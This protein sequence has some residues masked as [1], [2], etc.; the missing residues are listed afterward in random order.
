MKILKLFLSSL[1][2]VM[3]ATTV[4]AGGVA[5]AGRTVT[6]PAEAYRAILDRLDQLQHRVDEL[7]STKGSVEKLATDV[8]DIYD[9]LDRVETKTLQDRVNFGVELRTRLD[10]FKTEDYLYNYVTGETKNNSKDNMW[11]NRFRLNMSA[12]IMDGLTFHGRLTVFKNWS[13]NDQPM[14]FADANAAHTPADTSVKLDRAYIDWVVPGMPIP[15]AIT[16]GRQ[17][18]S[19]GPPFELRENR[20]RQS[21]YP[22]LLFDGESDGIVATFGLSKYT[23]IHNNGF[24]LA[25]F[26]GFQNNDDMVSYKRPRNFLDDLNVFA[27]FFEGE[28]PAVPNSLFVL[29]YVRSN[30]HVDNPLHPTAS[31]GD[32]DNYVIHTQADNIMETGLD[33]FISWG[34]NKSH[35]NGDFGTSDFMDP[36][37]NLFTFRMPPNPQQGIY[38]GI[39]MGLLDDDGDHGHT[40]W[41][42]YTGLRYT[43]PVSMLNLPK[44]GFEYNHGS[45]YWFSYTMGTDDIYN[46][47]ATRGDAYDIYYIQPFNRYL[48]LRTGYTYVDYDYTG[49]GWHIGKPMDTEESL[50]NFYVLLDCR[51]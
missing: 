49:S 3:A 18:S 16:F 27:T 9:T 2:I 23:H 32:M 13:D 5:P 46:K 45:K 43:I 35:P 37:G 24:R 38:P 7:E 39:G 20:L 34:L 33:F 1:C 11:T 10:N 12:D 14:M 22:S 15:L 4:Y 48:F 17:P 50:Q 19:E 6:L 47:L 44:I 29:G 28:I 36:A 51:F 8:D 40:G 31:I 42:I 26:K 30:G 25:Y 41:A 21:T